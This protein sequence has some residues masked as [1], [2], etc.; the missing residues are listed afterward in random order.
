[1]P[2]RPEADALHLDEAVADRAVLVPCDQSVPERDFLVLPDAFE[3]RMFGSAAL[4]L[5]ASMPPV[6]TQDTGP[7]SPELTCPS[8]PLLP[9]VVDLVPLVK[10]AL[11]REAELVVGA[12]PLARHDA[13]VVG[14]LA[15]V[16][17]GQL[18][19]VHVPGVAQVL[20]LVLSQQ[21]FLHQGDDALEG[22]LLALNARVVL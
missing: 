13:V 22:L 10:D 20:A 2:Q 16:L 7:A 15:V 5:Q 14:P 3:T 6:T 4:R 9:L 19:R 21:I 11:E 8:E 1:M 18:A 17:A 12:D